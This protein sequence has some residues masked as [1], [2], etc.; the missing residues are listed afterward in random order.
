M[1]AELFPEVTEGTMIAFTV[2]GKPV[3]RGSKS[4]WIPRRKDGSMVTRANGSPVIA[5][6]DSTKGRSRD[7]MASVRDNARVAYDGPLL[8]GPCMVSLSFVFVRPKSHFGTGKNSNRLKDSAPDRPTT[9]ADV[10]KLVR[11]MLDSFKGVIWRDDS[12]VTRLV[13]EKCW[14]EPACAIVLIEELL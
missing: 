1:S 8:Q 3:S 7:W 13:A 5:M 14:G 2:L 12:Q 4:A 6:M 11:P 9:E 10:D